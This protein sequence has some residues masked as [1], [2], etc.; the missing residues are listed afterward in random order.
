MSKSITW[1]SEYE[2]MAVM[3]EPVNDSAGHFLIIENAVPM[4][5]FQVGCDD[6]AAFFVAFRDNLK[7]Q[8][9]SALFKGHIAPFITDQQVTFLNLPHVFI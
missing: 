8:L 7:Q 3:N 4:A 9:G 5:E 1:A 2:K 6:N